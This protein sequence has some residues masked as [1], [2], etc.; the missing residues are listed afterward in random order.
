MGTGVEAAFCVLGGGRWAA[1]PNLEKARA[2]AE[3]C[4]ASRV[5]HVSLLSCIWADARSSAQVARQH[6][7]VAEL[8]VACGFGRL[9]IFQPSLVLRGAASEP[10]GATLAERAYFAAFPT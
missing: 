8:F 7:D 10:E 9:S 4:K 6:A 2:F 1:P 3:L 5:P